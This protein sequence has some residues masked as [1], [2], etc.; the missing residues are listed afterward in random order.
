MPIKACSDK[1]QQEMSDYGYPP[2]FPPDKPAPL[3]EEVKDPVDP[4]KKGKKVKSK[5]LAKS[6]GLKYQW[7]IMKSLG[8]KD[9]DIKKLVGEVLFQR[10]ND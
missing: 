9:E 3:T 5:V 2:N 7:L 1:L 10:F 6:S 4:T 8:M